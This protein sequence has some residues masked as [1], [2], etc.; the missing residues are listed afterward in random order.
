VQV[1]GR[2]CAG[3]G[4]IVKDG[5]LRAEIIGEQQNRLQILLQGLCGVVDG[6]NGQ[7]AG[8]DRRRIA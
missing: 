5:G 8:K 1:I 3:P 2:R 7:M 4:A 6:G